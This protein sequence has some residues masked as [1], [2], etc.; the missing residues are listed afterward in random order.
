MV[1]KMVVCFTN[2]SAEILQH[3]LGYS[4]WPGAPN[5]GAFLPHANAIKM[6]QKLS[7]QKLLCFG[8]KKC[9]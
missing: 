5:F 3:V 4:C 6:H 2:L 7:A 1:Q 9:W 8:T